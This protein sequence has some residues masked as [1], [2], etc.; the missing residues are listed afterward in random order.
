MGIRGEIRAGPEAWSLRESG[1]PDG[2]PGKGSRAGLVQSG[3]PFGAPLP[4]G[5]WGSGWGWDS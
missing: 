5:R 2:V 3:I 1:D 4:L